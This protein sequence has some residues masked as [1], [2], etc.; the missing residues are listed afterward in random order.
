VLFR[1][2]QNPKTP[3]LISLNL[4]LGQ[5]IHGAINFSPFFL[6]DLVHPARLD[7]WFDIIVAVLLKNNLNVLVCFV[8]LLPLLRSC[9]NNFSTSENK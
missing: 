2:P 8:N 7:R 6:V 4:I 3:F 1:S 5:E 9:K